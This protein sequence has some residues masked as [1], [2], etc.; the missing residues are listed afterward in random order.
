M[1]LISAARWTSVQ[2]QL[3][4]D[5]TF[6]QQAL[7]THLR[8][9]AVG[10]GVLFKNVAKYGDN[11]DANQ[12]LDVHEDLHDGASTSKHVTRPHKVTHLPLRLVNG[13]GGG[14]RRHNRGREEDANKEAT[15]M[16]HAFGHTEKSLVLKDTQIGNEC[17]TKKTKQP[18]MQIY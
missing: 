9:V 18:I 16:N 12:I 6:P 17:G 13:G 15:T 5:D 1:Q 3:R 11:V 7:R 2:V 4:I 10:M 8:S 14:A